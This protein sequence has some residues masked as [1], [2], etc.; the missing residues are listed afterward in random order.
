MDAQK[1]LI[2]VGNNVKQLR[3]RRELSQGGLAEKANVSRS[4]IQAI[5]KG[6]NIEL[7]HIL[8]I[9]VALNVN[10]AD[11]FLTEEDRK[12]VTYKAKLFWDSIKIES[13]K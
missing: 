1:Y 11:L 4:T 2:I 12:E 8:N 9:A 3:L 13:K 10:P 7:E 6:R 5:E